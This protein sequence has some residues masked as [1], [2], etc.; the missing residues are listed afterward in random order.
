MEISLELGY[1]N[2]RK[3]T[4]SGP[5]NYVERSGKDLNTSL[6][7]RTR[8]RPKSKQKEIFATTDVCIEIFVT[9]IEE[10]KDGPYQE[11]TRKESKNRPTDTY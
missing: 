2:K 3:F 8:N 4:S 6:T 1:L 9:I 10:F 7:L 5:S 11:Y